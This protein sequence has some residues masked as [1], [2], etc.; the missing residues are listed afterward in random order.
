MHISFN[1]RIS[2]KAV[3]VRVMPHVKVG[4]LRNTIDATASQGTGEI[5]VKKVRVVLIAVT[6]SLVNAAV[7]IKYICPTCGI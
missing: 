2:V 7:G 4:T 6:S 3:L 5:T 1:N